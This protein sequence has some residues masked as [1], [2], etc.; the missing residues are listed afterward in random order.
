[1]MSDDKVALFLGN[2]KKAA[3]GA[4]N[5]E[6]AR[7]LAGKLSEIIP[8]G[9]SVF[10]PKATDMEKYA[11]SNFDMIEAA[12]YMN[13]QVTVEEATAAIAETGSIVCTS[14][15][16]KTLQASLLPWQHVALVPKSRIFAT[17]DDFFAE[18]AA[19]PPTNITIIT[20]PS[21]TADIELNLVIG[22]HGPEKLDIIVV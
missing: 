13:A 4:Y 17:L 14:E 16:G 2:A 11:V 1:M 5:L 18:S 6:N 19:K 20:G 7:D 15:G 10:C 9:A 8:K 22:V 12:D 3:A 21:R